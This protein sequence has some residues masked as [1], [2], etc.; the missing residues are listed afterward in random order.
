MEAIQQQIDAAMKNVSANALKK[1]K[2]LC[3]EFRVTGRMLEG[4][5]AEGGKPKSGS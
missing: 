5:L 4:G 3:K 2:R 1:I